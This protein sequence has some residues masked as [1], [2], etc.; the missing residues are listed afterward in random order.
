[1]K[2]ID[3]QKTIRGINHHFEV[4]LTTVPQSIPKRDVHTE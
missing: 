4:R 2:I 1:M 3:G